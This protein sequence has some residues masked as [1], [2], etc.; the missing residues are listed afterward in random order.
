MGT[1]KTLK[2]FNF[3]SYLA[4]DQIKFIFKY[5]DPLVLKKGEIL[6]GEGENGD[7]VCFILKGELEV[8][9][10]STIQEEAN[11]IAILAEGQSIG[12]MVLIDNEPRTATVRATLPTKLIV[13]TQKAFD[14]VVNEKPAIGINVLKGLSRVLRDKLKDTSVKL[15]NEM[16]F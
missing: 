1:T 13:L 9:K 6:F 3:F 10:E 4:D 11:V 7:Y 2:R 14:M 5:M 16:R 12:E 15:A 8:I